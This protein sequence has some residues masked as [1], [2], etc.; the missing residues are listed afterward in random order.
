MDNDRFQCSKCLKKYEGRA[1]GKKLLRKYRKLQG[2]FGRTR[3]DGYRFDGYIY[4]T[5][6]GN[7]FDYSSLFIIELYR[8]YQKG[9]MPYPG[10]LVEQPAK[11]ME[12]FQVIDG[13]NS[14]K[15]AEEQ[16]KQKELQSRGRSRSH[17]RR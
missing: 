17:N 4:S 11:I 9:I 7:V 14:L 13:Y 5:C 6:P 8:E 12:A 16:K 10:A 15:L 2:C 1:D 3:R